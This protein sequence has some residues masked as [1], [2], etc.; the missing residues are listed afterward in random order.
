M[1]SKSKS[2]KRKR[3]TKQVST[4][5]H[6]ERAI[7]FFTSTNS[8]S[9]QP[10]SESDNIFDN[11]DTSS[12]DDTMETSTNTLCP[13]QSNVYIS[14]NDDSDN[15]PEVNLSQQY[16]ESPQ[17]ATEVNPTIYNSSPSD[18]PTQTNNTSDTETHNTIMEVDNDHEDMT[19]DIHT[20]NSNINSAFGLNPFSS[21]HDTNIETGDT[22]N[23]LPSTT[24]S[25]DDIVP[26]DHFNILTVPGDGSCFYH[27]ISH[28]LDY[29]YHIEINHLNIRTDSN[30]WLRNNADILIPISPDSDEMVS[31]QD[32]AVNS[33]YYKKYAEN[34]SHDVKWNLYI[35]EFSDPTVYAED[36]HIQAVSEILRLRI[37][38]HSSN[39]PTRVIIPV[40]QVYE[41]TVYIYLTSTRNHFDSLIRTTN[42]IPKSS[43]K[44]KKLISRQQSLGYNTSRASIRSPFHIILPKSNTPVQLHPHPNIQY[45]TETLFTNGQQVLHNVDSPDITMHTDHDDDD[46]KI[47]K[48]VYHPI[49][50]MAL[51]S[52]ST[53]RIPGT[54]STYSKHNV[55]S[56]K[57]TELPPAPYSTA[58]STGIQ[59]EITQGAIGF[60]RIQHAIDK[61]PA[62][63][64]RIP[65]DQRKYITKFCQKLTEV[66]ESPYLSMYTTFTGLPGKSALRNKSVRAKTIN[67]ITN[68]FSQRGIEIDWEVSI[69]HSAFRYVEGTS[70]S[71]TILLKFTK[72]VKVAHNAIPTKQ[73]HAVITRV[74]GEPRGTWSDEDIQNE[75]GDSSAKLPVLRRSYTI[76]F[77]HPNVDVNRLQLGVNV[78]VFR[79]NT[80]GP[81]SF[82]TNILL[83]LHQSLQND[84]VPSNQYVILLDKVYHRWYKSNTKDEKPTVTLELIYS[85][86]LLHPPLN[87]DIV[88]SPEYHQQQ[89]LRQHVGLSTTTTVAQ[90]Y[91]S[92]HRLEALLHFNQATYI[93]RLESGFVPHSSY[94][95]GGSNVSYIPIPNLS[96]ITS[97]QLLHDLLT[98]NSTAPYL[99]PGPIQSNAD[100]QAAPIQNIFIQSNDSYSVEPSLRDSRACVIIWYADRPPGFD[101]AAVSNLYEPYLILDDPW[102]PDLIEVNPSG[103]ESFRSQIPEMLH[104]YNQSRPNSTSAPR[105]TSSSRPD[106]TAS[107]IIAPPKPS[108]PSSSSSQVTPRTYSMAVAS[109]N[110]NNALSTS[111]ASTTEL[112]SYDPR[113]DEIIPQLLQLM[114]EQGNI[115][116]AM[117]TL[118]TEQTT[119]NVKVDTVT[120]KV[121][122]I[123]SNQT[124]L[125]ASMTL[126]HTDLSNQNAT[127]L[128]T[129][130]GYFQSQSSPHGQGASRGND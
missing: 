110:S 39:E 34:S 41:K 8:S 6:R 126:L 92:G 76:Q 112:V 103:F 78:M 73:I 57:L 75:K 94:L 27:A 29:K 124:T 5:S 111:P 49:R 106:T 104:Y 3:N 82:L 105:P 14:S 117:T 20:L 7:K 19:T 30:L 130:Q 65:T 125:Q 1:S 116:T 22:T 26:L 119:L 83:S 102:S 12:I 47:H 18:H 71:N 114:S 99:Y 74:Q 87:V 48:A 15:E 9:S 115:R 28:Q 100:E 128:A 89:Q 60:E 58:N 79:G 54:A 123:E 68:L 52:H 17:V 46:R 45:T 107:V 23:I 98:F 21:S 93:P 36:P 25:Q 2:T 69:Q 38:I 56:P 42:V 4:P 53:S 129:L 81:D 31:I 55:S 97:T 80:N 59:S 121:D 43:T 50:P 66:N 11:L 84:Q 72:S 35:D 13:T 33:E 122:T 77:I 32:S 120:S 40:T 64:H 10:H 67:E 44:S 16:P 37:C 88:T 96:S 86:I 109:G 91:A 63:I 61:V 95:L 101:P 90:W 118:R 108:T 51:D 127:L 113:V 85:V 70:S 24:Q 62:L